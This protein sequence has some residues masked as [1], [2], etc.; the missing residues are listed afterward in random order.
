MSSLLNRILSRSVSIG[1]VGRWDSG[2][3]V[4]GTVSKWSVVGW[5]MVG[6]SVLSGSLVGGFNKTHQVHTKVIKY[7]FC[8]LLTRCVGS[9]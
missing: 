3:W 1:S 8:D 6:W 9:K 7:Y 2:R 4:G 5:S